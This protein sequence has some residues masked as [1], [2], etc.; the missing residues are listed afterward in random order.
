MYLSDR[1]LF[2]SVTGTSVPAAASPGVQLAG[3]DPGRKSFSVFNDSPAVLYLKVGTS[4]STFDYTVQVPSLGLYES[5]VPC[6][7]TPLWGVWTSATGSAKVC[8]VS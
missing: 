6:P 8:S 2:V 5:Q 1:F 7:T 4:G 3:A